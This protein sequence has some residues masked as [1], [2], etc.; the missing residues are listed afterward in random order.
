MNFVKTFARSLLSEMPLFVYLSLVIVVH[1]I[2]GASL[3]S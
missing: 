1:A 3:L 2:I